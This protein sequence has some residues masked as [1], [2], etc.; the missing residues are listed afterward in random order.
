M[1]TTAPPFPLVRMFLSYAHADYV[2]VQSLM[3]R[4][5]QN[6]EADAKMRFPVWSDEQILIGADWDQSIKAALAR[7]DFGLLLLTPAA[8]A[9][10]YIQRTE[11]PALLAEAKLLL[12]GLRPVDF[13]LQLPSALQALQVFRL[14]TANGK[15]LFYTESNGGPQKD[16][17]AHGLYK[18]I[19]SRCTPTTP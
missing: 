8:L 9:S 19:R 6:L 15:D 14:K 11:I 7:S 10:G 17:F 1:P 18:A 2:D 3:G 5:N 13:R 4:L 16:A 12:V